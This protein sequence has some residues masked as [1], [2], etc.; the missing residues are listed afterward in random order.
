[1]TSGSEMRFVL[2]VCS[3]GVLP[4]TVSTTAAAA[5]GGGGDDDDN[6]HSTSGRMS[7]DDD[8]AASAADSLHSTSGRMSTFICIH[9]CC[10]LA[11]CCLATINLHCP[12]RAPGA[13]VF[14]VRIGPILFLAGC[15][16]RQLNQ[17]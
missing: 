17:G 11:S 14:F 1:M 15:R 3:V 13:V 2:C 9:H 10:A 7:T 5:A 6:Q 16:K 8:D 4:S 12:V